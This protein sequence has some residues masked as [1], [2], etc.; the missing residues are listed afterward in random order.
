MEIIA[1]ISGL[2]AVCVLVYFTQRRQIQYLERQNSELTQQTQE[3]LNALMVNQG[4]RAV[5]ND[6]KTKELIRESGWFDK[7]DDF[8][9]FPE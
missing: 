9:L 5:F 6:G 4:K 3:L 1:A 7:K 8:D 2:L